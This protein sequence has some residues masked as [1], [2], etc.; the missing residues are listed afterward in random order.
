M[1]ACGKG[2][3]EWRDIRHSGVGVTGNCELSQDW[4][5]VLWTYVL[6]YAHN[7]S[8]SSTSIDIVNICLTLCVFVFVLMYV[9]L[10]SPKWHVLALSSYH[11]SFSG[12]LNAGIQVYFYM[13]GLTLT[14][15]H[16]PHS[17]SVQFSLALIIA[18][19]TFAKCFSKTWTLDKFYSFVSKSWSKLIVFLSF[20]NYVQFPNILFI[21]LCSS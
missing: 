14:I 10:G 7:H 3:Q 9:R 20:H 6:S 16:H 15:D 13:F 11:S 18:V 2:V 1:Y 5:C 19:L 12:F 8:L 17:K 21:N 4:I